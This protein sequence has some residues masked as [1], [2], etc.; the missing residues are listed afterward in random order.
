MPSN[1]THTGSAAAIAAKTIARR[2]L[3]I[4]ASKAFSSRTPA[5]AVLLPLL[6]GLVP[7]R[8]SC[9]RQKVADPDR[10]H[11]TIIGFQGCQA[12]AVRTPCG[13]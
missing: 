12:S 9:S 3:D 7:G 2:T 10:L 13:P 5:A 8:A 6:S 4:A 1:E 11:Y